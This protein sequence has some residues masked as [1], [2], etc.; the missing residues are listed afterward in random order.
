MYLDVLVQRANELFFGGLFLGLVIGYFISELKD[1][2]PDY[3]KKS[4][5]V[6]C[7]A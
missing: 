4:S 7:N 5:L 6:G 3:K 1:D 2:N